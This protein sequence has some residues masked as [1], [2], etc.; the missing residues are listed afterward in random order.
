MNPTQQRQQVMEKQQQQQLSFQRSPI[1][2]ILDQQ[3]HNSFQRSPHQQ[4][5]ASQ[6][7]QHS[8]Q[9]F[10][11]FQSNQIQSTATGLQQIKPFKGESKDLVRFIADIDKI[12][13]SLTQL[14]DLEKSLQVELIL[15]K[16]QGNISQIFRYDNFQ[17]WDQLKS[18]LISKFSK[19][20]MSN[21]NCN[22]QNCTDELNQSHSSDVSRLENLN[23]P[24]D[25]KLTVNHILENNC[26]TTGRSLPYIQLNSPSGILK[27]L[28]DTGSNLNLIR[29]SLCSD[30]FRSTDVNHPVQF[31]NKIVHA[32]SI[33]TL[34]F[35]ELNNS[36]ITFYEMDFSNEFDGLLGYPQ[37]QL[38]NAV[39]NCAEGNIKIKDKSF[40]LNF[41][42]SQNT[43]MARKVSQVNHSI[44][45]VIPFA[46]LKKETFQPCNPVDKVM[47][48]FN[49][50]AVKEVVSQ[51]SPINGQLKHNFNPFAPIS[52]D[53]CQVNHVTGKIF[54][55]DKVI[56]SNLTTTP[57]INPRC[58][59][60]TMKPLNCFGNQFIF[61]SGST[62]NIAFEK[63]FRKKRLTFSSPTFSEDYFSQII[64]DHFVN[65]KII[66]VHFDNDVAFK[67]F[68]AVFNRLISPHSPMKVCRTNVYLKDVKSFE[69]IKNIVSND[70]QQS[71]HAD[72]DSIYLSIAKRYY[73]PNLKLI[74]AKILKKCEVCNSHVNKGNPE[75]G[76]SIPKSKSAGFDNNR[77]ARDSFELKIMK[78]DDKHLMCLIDTF[79]KYAQIYALQKTTWFAIK[80]MLL[81]S[82]NDMGK[83]KSII[84]NVSDAG[85]IT[86]EFKQ[87]LIEMNVNLI[88]KEEYICIDRFCNSILE[89]V[90]CLKKNQFDEEFDLINA[91][92]FGYN[93]DYNRNIKSTPQCIH[94][95]IK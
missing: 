43:P 16:I 65:K 76:S 55:E 40:P 70:H 9:K 8:Q 72:A 73:R 10:S 60:A 81:R 82:F 44:H 24:P 57:Q 7:Q 37:L 22:V 31:L 29:R 56:E 15:N 69:E 36:K 45:D 89:R 58:I 63:I 71:N 47:H 1:Q 21:S 50:F 91:A 3:Q 83:P 2:Q 30:Q 78:N 75:R 42:L 39:I 53:V 67:T 46:I 95:N 4:I 11:L 92:L 18:M 14:S 64:Q 5:L 54:I 85:L 77:R 51:L 87:F 80:N 35:E 94:Y 93:T 25:H 26:I 23:S 62:E 84:V 12:T 88:R 17:S 48:N 52:K 13:H 38:L 86:P 28:I 20:L 49:P 19:N 41:S 59:E 68:Q 34:P 33:C 32:S 61:K 90:K 74:I 6:Q 66:A 27:F 79:S